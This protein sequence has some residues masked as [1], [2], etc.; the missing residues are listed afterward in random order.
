MFYLYIMFKLINSQCTISFAVNK[1]LL[2]QIHLF[3]HIHTRKKHRLPLKL[4]NGT[5]LRDISY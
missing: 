2:E 3:I 1:P 5:L 4:D